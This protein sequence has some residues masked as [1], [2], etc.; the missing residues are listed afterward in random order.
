MPV[1]VQITSGLSSDLGQLYLFAFGNLQ[2]RELSDKAILSTGKTP[3]GTD[4][5]AG[6][7]LAKES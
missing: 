4:G 6:P 1:K 3:R 2:T 5:K 7:R